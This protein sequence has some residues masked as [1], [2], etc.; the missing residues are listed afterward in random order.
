ML[1]WTI[2]DYGD[3]W[4]AFHN[5]GLWGTFTTDRT[6]CS[7]RFGC[8][9]YGRFDSED[10]SVHREDVFIDGD[11]LRRGETVSAQWV[12]DRHDKV[13][14]IDS[15]DLV[16]LFLIDLAAFG[17]LVWWTRRF[18]IQPRRRRSERSLT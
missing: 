7:F 17:W 9:D 3:S 16:W 6:D 1:A 10:G 18:L 14:R 5:Q 8:T 11:G 4:R 13:Y 2:P 12:G 15:R